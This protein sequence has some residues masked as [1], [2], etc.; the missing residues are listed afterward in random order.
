MKVRASVKR[1]CENCKMVRRQGRLI[2]I[3]TQPASQ[4]APGLGESR[5]QEFIACRVFW[6]STSA[7]TSRRT[8]RCATSTA[9]VRRL[10][11][12]L[13]NKASVDPQRQAKELTDEEIARIATIL[14][15]DYTVEGPLRRQTAAEHPAA[16]GHRLLPRHSPSPR[17]AG[18]RPAD[19]D[20]RPHPQGAAQ[21]RGRQE[22]RQGNARLSRL[23]HAISRLRRY[24]AC[25]TY[26]R[27]RHAISRC[28]LRARYRRGEHPWPRARNAKRGATSAGASPT[29]RRPST[30][31]SSPSPTPTATRCA[32]PRP[33]RSASRAAARARRSPP[34]APP[35]RAPRRRRK[36]GLQGGRGPRQGARLR[37]RVGHHRPAGRRPDR[38][39]HRRRDAAAA[40]RL[41]AAQETPRVIQLGAQLTA[42]AGTARAV[43]RSA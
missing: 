6:V 11:L 8:F 4:A 24:T 18:A 21:D 20:Q 5:G 35:R 25:G 42:H 13:C 30:T 43:A 16:E 32:S 1:I 19:P 12:E 7:T 17:P 3:C 38:Q 36:F 22:G 10:A 28:G 23:R 37:P 39:G 41:P 33:A 14:D 9:S 34:S 27:L 2:V 40:Q 31:P 29:S 26:H 15:Q